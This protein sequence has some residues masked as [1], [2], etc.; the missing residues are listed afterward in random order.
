MSEQKPLSLGGGI[1]ALDSPGLVQEWLAWRMLVVDSAAW[2]AKPGGNLTAARAA[3]QLA[4]VW[5]KPPALMWPK[6]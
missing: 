2:W 6:A 4:L 1:G 3:T 5:V